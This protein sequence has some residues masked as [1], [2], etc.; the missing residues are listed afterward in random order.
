[1]RWGLP[2]IT[3]TGDCASQRLLI[4]VLLLALLSLA[5]CGGSA[6][7]LEQ[8]Q[9]APE[10]AGGPSIGPLQSEAQ[11]RFPGL[12]ELPTGSA[13]QPQSHEVSQAA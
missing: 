7:F 2:T 8:A 9:S 11:Q 10:A 13:Y 1:M 6:K 12:P 3:N 4:L 5:A